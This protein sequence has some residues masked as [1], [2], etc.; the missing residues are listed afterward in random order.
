MRRALD[1]SWKWYDTALLWLGVVLIVT[2]VSLAFA[3]Y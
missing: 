2:T 3:G 1:P